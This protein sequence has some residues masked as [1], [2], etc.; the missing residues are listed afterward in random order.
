MIDVEEDRKTFSK[1]SH[2]NFLAGHLQTNK[3][4]GG[5]RPSWTPDRLFMRIFFPQIVNVFE[6]L[7]ASAG[8]IDILG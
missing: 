4:I 1:K 7:K 6:K 2:R 8:D 5:H 3:K